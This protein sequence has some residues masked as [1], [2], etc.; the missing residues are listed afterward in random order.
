MNIPLFSAIFLLL[1]LPTTKNGMENPFKKY[2]RYCDIQSE[3]LLNESDENEQI[4]EGKWLSQESSD[5]EQ[6][7][8]LEISNLEPGYRKPW[9][10]LNNMT[11]LP[12]EINI[13]ILLKLDLKDFL[14]MLKT[15]RLR[16]TIC[17]EIII[18]RFLLEKRYKEDLSKHIPAYLNT[19]PIEGQA[20]IL[21]LRMLL[22]TAA[23]AGYTEDFRILFN[24]QSILNTMD[25]DGVDTLF[26]TAVKS[27]QIGIIK[28]LIA[29][30]HIEQRITAEKL[31]EC[32]KQ[33]AN[34]K[35]KKLVKPKKKQKVYNVIKIF[36]P[37]H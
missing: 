11:M 3:I 29:Y 21:N 20:E 27:E 35:I 32:I 31:E 26:A 33:S 22:M 17:S 23:K 36:Y 28:Q 8:S 7:I 25:D 4:T 34:K 14:T 5:S 30:N 37:Y 18:Q 13:Y 9:N 2:V 1:T 15:D 12:E 6:N 10:I 24:K 16:H 19:F